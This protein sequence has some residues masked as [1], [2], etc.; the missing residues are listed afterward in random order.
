MVLEQRRQRGNRQPRVALHESEKRLRTQAL[1]F[2]ASLAIPVR[3]VPGIVAEDSRNTSKVPAHDVRDRDVHVVLK[4]A[5]R[6]GRMIRAAGDLLCKRLRRT[7]GELR[8]AQ[9]LDEYARVSCTACL[10]LAKRWQSD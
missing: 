4:Q 6:D 1:T 9:G 3:W 8:F 10:T 5:I 2:N 7:G